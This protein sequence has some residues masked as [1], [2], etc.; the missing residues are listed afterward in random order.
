[1]NI[2]RIPK[3]YDRLAIFA[4]YDGTLVPLRGWEPHKAKPD[5]EILHLVREISRTPNVQ[6]TVIS[7][8]NFNELLSY[9]PF[10]G[11]YI[12][13]AHGGIIRDKVGKTYYLV[14][15][16][17][18][19]Y[20]VHMVERFLRSLLRKQHGFVLEDKVIGFALHYGGSYREVKQKI[21]ERINEFFERVALKGEFDLYDWRSSIELLHRSVSKGKSVRYILENFTPPYYFPVYIGDDITDRDAYDTITEFSGQFYF[22]GENISDVETVRSFLKSVIERYKRGTSVEGY[23]PKGKLRKVFPKMISLKDILLMELEEEQKSFENEEQKGEE[24]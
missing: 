5:R 9:F 18:V 24:L 20:S 10:K 22:V 21:H 14:P 23:E 8:R 19:R 6:F 7:G 17:K 12:A 3:E 11:L 13:G 2:F 15:K 16:S 1:M 4:D